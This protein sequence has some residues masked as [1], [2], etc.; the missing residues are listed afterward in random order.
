SAYWIAR[1][2]HNVNPERLEAVMQ[3]GV[4][5]VVDVDAGGS[6]NNSSRDRGGR[7][8]AHGS[9]GSIYLATGL[10]LTGCGKLFLERSVRPAI[11]SCLLGGIEGLVGSRHDIVAGNAVNWIVGYPAADS[12]RP[13]HAGKMMQFDL[14]AQLFRHSQRVFTSSF[15]R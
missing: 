8:S 12:H 6:R 5:S 15:R 14:A 1:D 11:A 7:R 13:G 10:L 9:L 4:A 3:E 2:R